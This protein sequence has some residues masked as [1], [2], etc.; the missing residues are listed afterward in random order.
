MKRI[1]Y[2]CLV[3]TISFLTANAS[4]A[5]KENK[6]VS[7]G[8]EVS[9]CS[10]EKTVQIF[11]K[12]FSSI[13]FSDKHAVELLELM[14][15]GTSKDGKVKNGEKYPLMIYGKCKEMPNMEVAL[16][17]F[18]QGVDSRDYRVGKF[19]IKLPLGCDNPLF[20]VVDEPLK[21]AEARPAEK[22][23]APSEFFAVKA[24]RP[25]QRHDLRARLWDGSGT[26]GPTLARVDGAQSR[27]LGALLRGAANEGKLKPYGGCYSFQFEF[28]HI[29]HELARG[30]EI[31]V[32]GV[33]ARIPENFSPSQNS[34]QVMVC[35][36]EGVLTIT[37][38]DRWVGRDSVLVIHSPW[39]ARMLNYP[40]SGRLRTCTYPQ[41]VEGFCGKK[42]KEGKVEFGEL[43]HL[44]HLNPDSNYHFVK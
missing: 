7:L 30:L 9:E 39:G 34:F 19:L 44:I 27:D 18:P 21:P 35:E 15:R 32:N 16:E 28:R 31:A 3:L 29:E 33:A 42:L 10:P 20:S 14:K 41:I 6:W 12:R 11:V 43:Y 4:A 24:E 17:H 1:S 23:T 25:P 13:G 40:P 22:I 26:D 8:R 36:G 37:D 5:G 2:F 38:Y